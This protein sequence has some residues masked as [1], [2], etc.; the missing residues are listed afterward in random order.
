LPGEPFA[1]ENGSGDD[2]LT[3]MVTLQIRDAMVVMDEISKEDASKLFWMIDRY[4]LITDALQKEGKGRDDFPEDLI[5]PSSEDWS[6]GNSLIGVVRKVKPTVIIGTSTHAGAF[7]EEVVRAMKEHCDRPIILPLSNPSK[8][9]EVHPKDANDWTEG[10]AL[11]ATGSP[12]EPVK[13]PNG[14]KDYM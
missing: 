3:D 14:K 2:R 9:V 12:F 7:T 4:G 10:K 6:D 11:I 1:E 13:M 5:R 8:L